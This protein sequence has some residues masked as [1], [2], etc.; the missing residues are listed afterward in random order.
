MAVKVKL[1]DA[2]IAFCNSIWP[3]AAEQYQG[4]GVAR[5]SATF[6]VEPDSANHKAIEAAILQAAKEKWT[7][8]GQAE[9]Q[10]AAMRGNTNKFCYQ[11]GDLKDYDGFAGMMY[12]AG[13]RKETDGAPKLL[14]N[15]KSELKNN[16]R[17]FAGCYVNAVVEIYAQDGEN[18]GIRCGLMGIQY[19]RI[20][21]SFGGASQAKDDDFDAIETPA[22]EDDFA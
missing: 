3:G 14:D 22:T 19:A 5:H 21:D 11:S 2:R 13:H 6:L 12:L 17:L 9:K 8:P 20:G 18:S 10:I 7:K 16:G 1:T 15:D 4:K